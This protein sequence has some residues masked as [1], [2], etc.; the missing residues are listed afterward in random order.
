VETSRPLIQQSGHTLG[1]ELPSQPVLVDADATRLTQVF[2]NLLNNAAKYTERGG[3]I[4]L[5]VEVEDGAALISVRDTG[6]GI[7]PTML[8]RVFDLFTQVDHSLEKTR[9]GLGI[10]LSLVKG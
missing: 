4:R 5:G 3:S 9:G 10:G 8:P 7:P 2:A 1:I 6:I